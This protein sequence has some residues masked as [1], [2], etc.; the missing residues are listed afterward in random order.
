MRLKRVDGWLEFV[1]GAGGDKLWY[2]E[3]TGESR[4]VPAQQ[5]AGGS[6]QSAWQMYRDPESG[7]TYWYNSA[8]GVSQWEPPSSPAA[9]PQAA[10]DSDV[11]EVLSP[12]D[13]GV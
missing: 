13:L 12:E 3:F 2:N 4:W 1:S 11:V 9:H 8:T 7:L 6:P 10:D 5:T